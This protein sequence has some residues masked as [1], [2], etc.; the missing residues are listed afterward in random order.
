MVGV[1]LAGRVRVIVF[2]DWKADGLSFPVVDPD[3]V[4]PLMSTGSESVVS[5]I[6]DLSEFVEEAPIGGRSSDDDSR[7]GL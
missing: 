6:V 7:L 5:V 3:I 2:V 4:G 1:D